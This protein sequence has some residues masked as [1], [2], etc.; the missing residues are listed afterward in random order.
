MAN[1]EV[2]TL[3]IKII[4]YNIH[5]G[6]SPFGWSNVLDQM[7]PALQS[8]HADFVLLQ[9]VK[10]AAGGEEIKGKRIKEQ[11]AQFE[12]LAD[13]LW[14]Y[15]AYG[16]N[17]VYSGGHHGNCILSRYPIS[18]WENINVSDFHFASRSVLH[19]VVR[20]GGQKFVDQKLHL[21]CLHLGL[22]ES[23]RLKQLKKLIGR[24]C[25][26]VPITEP[27]IIAGDF[28]DWFSRIHLEFRNSLGLG[29]AFFD[30]YGQYAATFPA[31]FPILP[32][33]RIYYRNL[34][35]IEATVASRLQ[36]KR[37]SDHLPLLAKFTF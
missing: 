11:E 6:F 2:P 18:D 27:L 10:G 9:E 22:F 30:L 16:K 35:L 14:P 12:Y 26:H 7:R 31:W 17:A 25:S 3:D 23:E 1:I 21:V 13:S 37:L 34:K 15:H 29:E 24:I 28:N 20:F 4:S 32:L 36:W 33:D 19:A 8:T 5:K